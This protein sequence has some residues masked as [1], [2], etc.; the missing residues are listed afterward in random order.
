MC[1]VPTRMPFGPWWMRSAH[2]VHWR[3]RR[4]ALKLAR[5]HLHHHCGPL[6]RSTS[7]TQK[8][9][10]LVVGWLLSVAPFLLT[11]SAVWDTARTT[12]PVLVAHATVV[13]L[14]VLHHT[15]RHPLPSIQ[16]Q[17]IEPPVS[18]RSTTPAPRAP[19][20]QALAL[21]LHVLRQWEAPRLLTLLQ[22]HRPS[23]VLAG[24]VVALSISSAP[25]VSATYTVDLAGVRSTTFRRETAGVRRCGRARREPLSP[26]TSL[27]STDL[28]GICP[29]E[30]PS[31]V[32]LIGRGSRGL[33]W[34]GQNTHSSFGVV[35]VQETCTPQFPCLPD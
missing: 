13:P 29:T 3:S 8:S 15:S 19:Q 34:L 12:A 24:D 17:A 26:S 4:P 16:P 30:H 25:Q 28:D 14:S 31:L 7:P 32:V 2:S 27:A 6:R 1:V 9:L 11:H 5:L 35:C 10:H 33:P 22:S 20:H 23:R 18:V 21:L